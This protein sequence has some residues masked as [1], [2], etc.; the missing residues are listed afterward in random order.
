MNAAHSSARLVGKSDK[1]FFA[2]LL[3]RFARTRRLP[4]P[5]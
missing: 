3:F 1:Y 4:S 2:I 5:S